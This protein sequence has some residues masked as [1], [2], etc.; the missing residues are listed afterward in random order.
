MIFYSSPWPL[1]TVQ[2]VKKVLAE[3]ASLA[4]L[5]FNPSKSTF[6]CSG[7][8]GV[9][10]MREGSLPV[11]YLGLPLISNKL[12]TG[13][14]EALIHNKTGRIDSWLSRNLSFDGR[15][16][17]LSSVSYGIQ[18]YWSNVFILPK[19]VIKTLAKK[20]NCFLWNRGSEGPTRAKFA[21]ESIC[22]PKDEEDWV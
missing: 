13:D 7:V 21:W 8:W 9:F 3:F 18:A 19:N 10:E 4:G 12:S 6:F 15:L 14:C 5:T 22:V 17:L 2:C 20:F 16:Q 11:R 1:Q